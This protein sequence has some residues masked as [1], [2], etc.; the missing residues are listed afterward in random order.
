MIDGY[1]VMAHPTDPQFSDELADL[2]RCGE[3]CRLFRERIS[4]GR[5]GFERLE[6]ERERGGKGKGFVA[7]R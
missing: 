5:L 4:V 2:L 1:D 6:R 7:K 3:R